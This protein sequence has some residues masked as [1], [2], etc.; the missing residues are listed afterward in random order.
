MK[1][2]LVYGLGKSGRAAAD[3]LIKKGYIVEGL[4]SKKQEKECVFTVTLVDKFKEFADFNLVIISPGISSSDPII[5]RFISLGVEVIG[6]AE[7]G[8]RSISNKV[9]AITGTNGKSSIVS[10]LVHILKVAG[11]K[12]IA[13][14]NIGVPISSVALTLDPETIIIA[15][16]SSFQLETMKTKSIDIAAILEITP[17]HLERYLSFDH[18]LKTKCRIEDF[19]KVDGVLFSI[20]KY[21]YLKKRAIITE[22]VRSFAGSIDQTWI[23]NK[24]FEL[25]IAICFEFDIPIIQIITATESYKSLPHRLEFVSESNG[26]SFYNDSKST[27]IESTIYAVNQFDRPLILLVGG[28]GKGGSYKL[29]RDSFTSNVKKVIAFGEVSDRIVKDLQK[30]ILIEKRPCLRSALKAAITLATRGDVVL[31]SPGCASFDAFD[32]YEHRGREFIKGVQD[33][34]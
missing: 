11:R 15:E 30:C 2:A 8:L 34:S 29:W 10:L 28:R 24:A 18:Y 23:S 14:G 22:N 17:D 16:I 33:E 19:L 27:N 5:Q 7:L 32:N 4:D 21:Q 25:V 13:L 6:E 9:V 3:L 20:E 26:I 12:A 1:K 31:L